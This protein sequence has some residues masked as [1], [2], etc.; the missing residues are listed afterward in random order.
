VIKK[1]IILAV[2][3]WAFPLLASG[4]ETQNSKLARTVKYCAED[5]R[6]AYWSF[7]AFY[8]PATRQVET[9]APQVGLPVMIVLGQ[10]ALFAFREC[11]ADQGMPL[12]EPTK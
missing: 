3:L 1:T 10:Q 12:G 2:T 6:K 5:T 11:M 4:S 7:D 9:N 8:N